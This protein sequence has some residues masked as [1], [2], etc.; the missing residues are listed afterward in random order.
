MNGIEKA[1]ILISYPRNAFGVPSA[2]RAFI[3]TDFTLST[4]AILHFYLER[5][6]IEIFFRQAKQK[7]AFDKYQIRS[8][9]GIKR[10]WLLMSLAHFICCT[11]SGKMLSFEDGFSFFQNAIYRERVEYI[12]RCGIAHL[13]LEDV[14]ASLA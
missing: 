2:L 4:N 1:A 6:N 9:Q 14:L 3:S 7:L 12:Y 10:F 8:S 5:W 13:P 11:G